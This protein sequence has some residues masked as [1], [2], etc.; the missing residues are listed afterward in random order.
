MSQS[1]SIPRLLVKPP[2]A[3]EILQVSPRKL[4]DLT[5]RG[6]VPAVKID[7]SVRYAVA[8][9]RAFVDGLTRTGAVAC[10]PSEESKARA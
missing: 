8:D 2:D 5:A 4:A 7:G 1:S 6:L 3:A 9:L 10:A